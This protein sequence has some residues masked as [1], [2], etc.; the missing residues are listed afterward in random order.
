MRDKR[1]E[2]ETRTCVAPLSD[3]AMDFFLRN[4]FVKKKNNRLRPTFYYVSSRHGGAPVFMTHVLPRLTHR[5]ERQR[6]YTALLGAR[7][8]RRRRPP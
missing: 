7:R 2:R 5:S 1:D 3:A 8:E 6:M 4:T